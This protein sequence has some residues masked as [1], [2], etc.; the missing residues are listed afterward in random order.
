MMDLKQILQDAGLDEN[1]ITPVKNPVKISNSGDY[2]FCPILARQVGNGTI[3]IL[4]GKKVVCEH[5]VV[6][7]WSYKLKT[8]QGYSQCKIAG[9]NL[10]YAACPYT[11]LP[12]CGEVRGN[13]G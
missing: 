13:L 9:K 3:E 5:L 8:P 10:G 6:S 11:G 1:E 4:P 7:I 2:K 12:D